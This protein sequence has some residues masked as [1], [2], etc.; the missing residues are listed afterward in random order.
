[1]RRAVGLACGKPV[2]RGKSGERL[3]KVSGLTLLAGTDDSISSASIS[4]SFGSLAPPYSGRA[5]VLPT[6]LTLLLAL[7]R[8]LTNR[9]FRLQEALVY[10]SVQR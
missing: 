5:Q 6:R 2:N 9:D 10:A 4:R 7:A 1:M 8:Q 3:G